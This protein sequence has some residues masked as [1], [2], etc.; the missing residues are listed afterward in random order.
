MP[1]KW[2]ESQKVPKTVYTLSDGESRRTVKSTLGPK[3]VVSLYKKKF[4]DPTKVF[5][6]SAE[7]F[8]VTN[9]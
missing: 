1:S 6:E 5:V 7:L 9:V 4:P 2:Y 8:T 3:L